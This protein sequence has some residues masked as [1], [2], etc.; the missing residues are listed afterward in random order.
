MLPRLLAALLT[1]MEII[2][3]ACDHVE[4]QPLVYRVKATPR[5]TATWE[6]EGTLWKLTARP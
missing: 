4:K 5:Q 2:L 3:M 1:A 6:R